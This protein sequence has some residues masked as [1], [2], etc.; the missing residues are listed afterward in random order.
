[1]FLEE[2]EVD[3][4]LVVVVVNGGEL[5]AADADTVEEGALVV[6]SGRHG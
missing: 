4:I 5:V 3:D 6:I 2:F 1:M